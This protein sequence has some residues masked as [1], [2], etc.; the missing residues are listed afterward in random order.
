MGLAS[1]AWLGPAAVLNVSPTPV[2]STWLVLNL[3]PHFPT[4]LLLQA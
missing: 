3:K 2:P 4:A 1:A